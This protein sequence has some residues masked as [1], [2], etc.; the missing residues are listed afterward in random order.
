MPPRKTFA[1]EPPALTPTPW[2]CRCSHPYRAH[3][4]T[5][6]GCECID[7]WKASREC[8]HYDPPPRYCRAEVIFDPPPQMARD[9]GYRGPVRVRCGEPAHDAA[10]AADH[11]ARHPGASP[12]DLFPELEPGRHRRKPPRRNGRAAALSKTAALTIARHLNERLKLQAA[13]QQG[14]RAT[15][16]D[17]EVAIGHLD[18]LRES[19]SANAEGAFVHVWAGSHPRWEEAN[20]AA[21]RDVLRHAGEL[22][23]EYVAEDLPSL[24]EAV[25]SVAGD[26]GGGLGR[27]CTRRDV[28]DALGITPASLKR[29]RARRNRRRRKQG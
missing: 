28:A 20:L 12:R 16:K 23:R 24:A 25:E 7:C 27:L 15:A 1:P 9:L 17:I 4:P 10:E 3:R 29:M 11:A 14:M 26:L 13:A 8:L 2:L 18:R 19:D 5:A 21:L 22:L 6:H